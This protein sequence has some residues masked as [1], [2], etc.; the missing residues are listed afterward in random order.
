M[1]AAPTL[2]PTLSA[3][4]LVPGQYGPIYTD[5]MQHQQLALERTRERQGRL[6]LFMERGT[7]KTRVALRYLEEQNVQRALV[8]CPISV[9]SEWADEATAIGSSFAV[10]VAMDGPVATRVARIKAFLKTHTRVLL[11]LSYNGFW[12]PALS[13]IIR[14]WKPE[15]VIGD[16]AHRI[17]HRGSRRSRAM[18]YFALQ[19]WCRIRMA[20]TGTPVTQA[21][22]DVFSIYKF[23]DPTIFGTRWVDFAWKYLVLGG[24]SGDKVIGY[25]NEDEARAR[26]AATSFQCARSDAIDLPGLIPLSRDVVLTTDSSDRYRALRRDALVQIT[27]QDTDGNTVT[28]IA[29]AR[30]RFTVLLR[31]QQLAGGNI[32][33]VDNAEVDVSAEK[34]EAAV[35]LAEQVLE[36]GE[37]VVIACRFRREAIRIAGALRALHQGRYRDQVGLWM[38]DA[39]AA[40]RTRLKHA[41]A[42]RHLRVMVGT[43]AVMA[44]G[45]NELVGAAVAIVV[46]AGY[47]FDELMQFQG[48]FERIG[49]TKPTLFY[50]L[51]AR[52]DDGSQTVDHT[53][54]KALVAK[55]KLAQRIVDLDYVRA[56]IS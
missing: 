51:R 37:Q 11:V 8:I 18:F 31:L 55:Q 1:V 48:R 16:E 35:D 28:G 47:S 17:K 54:H 12:M 19:S 29:L 22:E 2:S 46:S 10:F 15:A 52:L 25:R 7:G 20:L 40:E 21:L 30:I 36:D 38:G 26:V 50:F 56:L 41:F 32:T 4:P 42:A 6:G 34:V 49:Q 9:G 23:I 44:E 43:I 53:I 14:T 45:V 33:T 39:N 27:G 24:Y 3:A 5:L 13:K